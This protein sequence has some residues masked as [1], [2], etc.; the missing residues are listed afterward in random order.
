MLEKYFDINAKG[1]SIKA[2][3]YCKEMGLIKRVTLYNHGFGGNK[4]NKST[5]RFAERLIGKDK[6]MAILCID[7]P[8]HGNDVKKKLTIADCEEYI[9]CTLEYI[10]ER[11]KTEEFYSYTNS[12]G[13]YV[14]LDYIHQYGNPFKKIILR[15]PALDMSTLVVKKIKESPDYDKLLKGKE[16]VYNPDY[17]IKV[18]KT[19]VN[20]LESKNVMEYD[21][22]EYADDILIVHGTKDEVIP[23]SM[24]QEF[25]D[26]NV[27]EL[28]TIENADHRFRDSNLLDLAISEMIKFLEAA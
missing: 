21:F 24:V 22:I 17:D 8:C 14:I 15:C 28:V 16:I 27:I 11:F 10:K 13:G 7:F 9:T 23:L 3:L 20:E 4:E 25:S 18:S 19:Y 26:N 5:K 6:H 12:M 2:K 1:H